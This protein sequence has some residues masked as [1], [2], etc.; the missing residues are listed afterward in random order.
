VTQV[1]AST[2][3]SGLVW[4]ERPERHGKDSTIPLRFL[5]GPQLDGTRE[6]TRR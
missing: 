1:A 4:V 2:G 3:A 5:T 6:N